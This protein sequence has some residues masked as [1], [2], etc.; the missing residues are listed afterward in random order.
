MN[1][2]LTAP[3]ESAALTVEVESLLDSPEPEGIYRDTREC[4]GGFL[5]AGLLLVSPPTPR[6]TKKNS[7]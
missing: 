2:D 1:S 7:H 5:L 3:V 6:P 4:G